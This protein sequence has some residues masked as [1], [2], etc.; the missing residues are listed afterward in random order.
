MSVV[1]GT[2]LRIVASML[3]TDGEV[4]QNVFNAKV[5]GAGGPWD[6]ADIVD[7]AVGWADTMYA[8]ITSQISNTLDGNYVAV[9][10]Y[11]AVHDDW[12][13]VGS[14]S[15]VWNPANTGENTPRGCAGLIRL[16]TEDPDVQGKKYIAGFTETNTSFGTLQ[17][18]PLAAMANFAGAWW[19]AFTGSVSGATWTPGIWSVVG[20]VLQIALEH[21]AASAIVAYQR[22]RKPN[23]GI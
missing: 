9:Y 19:D 8:H 15:W 7:D 18:T 23:V 1:E 2:I 5:T 6:E 21:Y 13:E 11:D 3:W 12:D 16:W 20:K 10:K 4:A 22:R 14:A 17:A